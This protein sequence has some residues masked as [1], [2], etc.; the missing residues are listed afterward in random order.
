MHYWLFIQSTRV[1]LKVVLRVVFVYL[2]G[3]VTKIVLHKVS[4]VVEIRLTMKVSFQGT[5]EVV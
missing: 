4:S 3:E 2:G 1:F 5:L